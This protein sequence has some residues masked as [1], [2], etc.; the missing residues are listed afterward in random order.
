[1]DFYNLYDITLQLLQYKAYHPLFNFS[2]YASSYDSD[3]CFLSFI[4]LYS[5][6]S[7]A[8]K[9]FLFYHILLFFYT[10]SVTITFDNSLYTLS[11]KFEKSNL[12][13]ITCLLD[14]KEICFNV[15][16]DF[17]SFIEK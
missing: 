1:M 11:I 17:K 3:F 15:N 4:C 16:A 9:I 13:P 5:H 6:P 7:N 14:I 8:F 10:F 12:F 2:L